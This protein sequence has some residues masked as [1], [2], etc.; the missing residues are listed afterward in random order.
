MHEGY[1]RLVGPSAI[2]AQALIVA[3]ALAVAA[4]LIAVAWASRRLAGFLAP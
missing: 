2:A 4:P 3:A 1:G